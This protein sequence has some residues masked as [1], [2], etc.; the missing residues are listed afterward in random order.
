MRIVLSTFIAQAEVEVQRKTESASRLMQALITDGTWNQR[1]VEDFGSKIQQCATKLLKPGSK[2]GTL[3]RCLLD[4]NIGVLRGA[5]T[6]MLEDMAKGEFELDDWPTNAITLEALGLAV[7]RVTVQF[8]P[9]SN[10]VDASA[11]TPSRAA[12]FAAGA[13][14]PLF[15]NAVTYAQMGSAVC[16]AKQARDPESESGGGGLL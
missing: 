5:H 4:D 11:N 13:D 7:S 12:A 10:W 6:R 1:S 16:Q 14:G 2:P 3:D 15:N 8:R 9:A